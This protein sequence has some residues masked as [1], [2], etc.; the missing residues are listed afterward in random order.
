MK[1]TVTG[2]KYLFDKINVVILDDGA[3]HLLRI[4]RVNLDSLDDGQFLLTRPIID[5][6]L[7]NIGMSAGLKKFVKRCK[8]RRSIF[9]L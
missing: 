5:N 3:K 1:M 2:R 7:R 4:P 8:N 6:Y 9:L